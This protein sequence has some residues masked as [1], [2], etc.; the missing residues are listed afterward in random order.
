MKLFSSMHRFAAKLQFHSNN[1]IDK[2]LPKPNH[3]Q[4]NIQKISP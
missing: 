4:M 3:N 1:P 2:G